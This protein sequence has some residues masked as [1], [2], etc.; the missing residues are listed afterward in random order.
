MLMTATTMKKNP[1]DPTKNYIT[2]TFYQTSTREDVKIDIVWVI[3]NSLSMYDEQEALA[4]NFDSFINGFIQKHFDFKM[5][6]TTI[7]P[8]HQTGT[9][10]VTSSLC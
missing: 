9:S 3:D 4:N 10:I 6:I 5:A 7:D 2:E 8:S 1:D